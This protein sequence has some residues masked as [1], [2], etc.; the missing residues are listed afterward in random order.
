[1]LAR[2]RYYERSRETA[3][4]GSVVLF[5]PSVAPLSMAVRGNAAFHV[6]V[7]QRYTHAY[8][9]VPYARLFTVPRVPFI[10]FKFVQLSVLR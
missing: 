3:A 8:I 2:N 9:K 1:M 5:V 6:P 10:L 7:T 4:F